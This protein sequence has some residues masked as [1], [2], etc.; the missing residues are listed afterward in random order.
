M[1]TC[2]KLFNLAVTRNNINGCNNLKIMITA[3]FK[4]KLQQLR[5]IK[6]PHF[7]RYRFTTCVVRKEYFDLT[8]HNMEYQKLLLTSYFFFIRTVHIKDLPNMFSSIDSF[9]SLNSIISK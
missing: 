1:S 5:A 7:I 9:I 2:R 8:L 4:K 3:T 6:K